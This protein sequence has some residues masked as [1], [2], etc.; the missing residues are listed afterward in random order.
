MAILELVDGI[1]VAA[2]CVDCR[3]FPDGL[4]L[5]PAQVDFLD[6]L[7]WVRL[8]ESGFDRAFADAVIC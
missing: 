2:I 6:G 3:D 5:I 7:F 1:A 8:L 4:L